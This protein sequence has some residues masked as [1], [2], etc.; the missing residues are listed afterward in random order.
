[1]TLHYFVEDGVYPRVIETVTG[2]GNAIIAVDNKGADGANRKYVATSGH[3]YVGYIKFQEGPV[4]EGAP[5]GL[6]NEDLLAVVIDR[7]QGFQSGDL[8]CRENRRALDA[9]E[10]ALSCLRSRTAD[11]KARGA[12]GTNE[13]YGAL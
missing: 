8:A 12:E 6:T 11:R 2:S 7:L 4:K 1:M 3:Q 5:G 13:K 9:A 10:T